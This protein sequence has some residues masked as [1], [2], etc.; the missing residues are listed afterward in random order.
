MMADSGGTRKVSGKTI[1][2]PFT[3]PNPGMA[4]INRPAVT[5][6]TTITMLNRDSEVEKPSINKLSVSIHFVLKKTYCIGGRKA[7]RLY[8][9]A[10]GFLTLP[11]RRR[12]QLLELVV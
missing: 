8:P 2:T 5:P 6:A 7:A 12:T 4:P 11:Q 3:D 9:L 1:A 10:I